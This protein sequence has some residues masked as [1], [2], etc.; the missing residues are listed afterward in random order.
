MIHCLGS[1]LRFVF[2][3]TQYQGERPRRLTDRPTRTRRT[4]QFPAWPP[5]QKKAKNGQPLVQRVVRLLD[6]GCQTRAL[7]SAEKSYYFAGANVNIYGMRAV[8]IVPAMGAPASSPV[9]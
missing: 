7:F 1:S 4:F 2:P 8:K 6:S 3:L 9:V 5:I